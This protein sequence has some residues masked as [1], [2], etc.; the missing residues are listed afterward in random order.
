[1]PKAI[2][3]PRRP[4]PS[5]VACDPLGLLP[6]R[7]EESDR[8]SV[9]PRVCGQPRGEVVWCAIGI[10]QVSLQP[11]IRSLSVNCHGS[12]IRNFKNGDGRGWRIN[13]GRWGCRSYHC[14]PRGGTSVRFRNLLPFQLLNPH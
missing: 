4:A 1:M 8:W 5:N 3:V 2:A 7:P 12:N 14:G 13:G 6:F 11:F 9:V 10:V